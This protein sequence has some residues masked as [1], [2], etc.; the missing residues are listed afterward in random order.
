MSDF[1]SDSFRLLLETVAAQAKT[2]QTQAETIQIL[3][4]GETEESDISAPARY[5]DGSL[6]R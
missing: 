5:M 3:M 4:N 2:I 6:A 1:S